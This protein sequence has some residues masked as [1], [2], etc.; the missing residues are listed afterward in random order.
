MAAWRIEKMPGEYEPETPYT[1]VDSGKEVSWGERDFRSE[2]R[3]MIE[4][5]FPRP[6]GAIIHAVRERPNTS[7]IVVKAQVTNVST[8]TLQTAANGAAVHVIVYEGHRA[9][10]TGRIVHATDYAPFT[11]PLRPGETATFE[12]PFL[13]L[14]GVSVSRVDAVVMVDYMPDPVTGRWDMLQAAIAGAGTLP[15]PPTP[16]PT[17]T[18]TPR[19]TAV[20]TLVPTAIPTVAPTAEPVRFDIYLPQAVRRYQVN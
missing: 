14:R 19:P 10:Q 11:N 18:A 3:A 5:E 17:S 1:M 8:V 15:A 9:L 20:P 16:L 2:F 4:S 12:F 13:K 7:S 6:P